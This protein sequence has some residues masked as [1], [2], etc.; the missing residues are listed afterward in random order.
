M[1]AYL[2]PRT[3]SVHVQT[4]GPP[5]LS[6]VPLGWTWGISALRREGQRLEAKAAKVEG[7]PLGGQPHHFRGDPHFCFSGLGG[8]PVGL[9]P[10]LQIMLSNGGGSMGTTP[11][12]AGHQALTHLA[13]ASSSLA[14][15]LGPKMYKDPW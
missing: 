2:T 4:Q 14:L 8:A 12:L 7:Q 3:P 13:S 6:G 1:K 9:G 5:H 15:S 11:V 10:I